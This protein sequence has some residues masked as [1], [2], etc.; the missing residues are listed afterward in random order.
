M[1]NNIILTVI[2][3]ND[4]QQQEKLVSLLLFNHFPHTSLCYKITV[5]ITK[6]NKIK[7]NI[8]TIKDVIFFLFIDFFDFFVCDFF[9]AT[10]VSSLSTVEIHR[11]FSYC[12]DGAVLST[13]FCFSPVQF[14]LLPLSVRQMAMDLL[15]QGLV[16]AVMTHMATDWLEQ[17]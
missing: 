2:P 8:C 12:S 9:F 17:F 6:G 7:S 3:L 5:K 4:L 1:R 14:L 16:R 11:L 10:V 15:K 13:L